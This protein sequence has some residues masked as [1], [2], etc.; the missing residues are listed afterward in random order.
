MTLPV[1]KILED[2]LRI[3]QSEVERLGVSELSL[4]PQMVAKRQT[5]ADFQIAL[6]A[7]Q[8]DHHRFARDLASIIQD[9][10]A[11]A[12]YLRVAPILPPSDPLDIEGFIYSQIAVETPYYQ[13]YELLRLPYAILEEHLKALTDAGRITVSQDPDWGARYSRRSL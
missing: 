1:S 8:I 11:F 12:K 9:P 3:V 2:A 6:G 13:L 10:N 7:G 5:Q 4:I